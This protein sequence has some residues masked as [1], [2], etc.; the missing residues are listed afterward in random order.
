M[1]GVMYLARTAL[2][3][4]VDI[5]QTY[6]W[7][8]SGHSAYREFLVSNRFAKLIL[9]KGWRGIKLKVVELL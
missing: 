1:R 6:E 8:G 7:F 4:D 3:S 5:L 9:E 2:V